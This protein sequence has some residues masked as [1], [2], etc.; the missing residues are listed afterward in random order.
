MQRPWRGLL[1]SEVIVR[2]AIQHERLPLPAAMPAA[3]HD[4][5]Q[6]CWA[7]GPAERPSAAQ[8]LQ[9]MQHMQGALAARCP[10]VTDF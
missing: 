1:P 4:L 10:Q 2:V 3:V 5:V 7:K 6:R 8:L 9:Q